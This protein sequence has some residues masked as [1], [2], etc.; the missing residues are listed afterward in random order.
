MTEIQK[1]LLGLLKEIDQICRENDITYYLIG[2]TALGAV[3]HR[4][5]IPW[6]DDADI[7]MTRENWLKFDALMK[8][9]LPEN[10]KYTTTFNTANNPA[11]FYRYAE[12]DSTLIVRSLS[13][14]DIVSGIIIDIFVLAPIPNGENERSKYHDWMRNYS[15]IL[16]PCFPVSFESNYYKYCFNRGLVRL[17]GRE[18]I[19]QHYFKKLNS[20]SEEDCTHYS[21]L[22][23]R[24]HIIYPKE[25]FGKPRYVP[26]ED[27]MLPIPTKAEDHFRILFGDDWNKLPDDR[28][29]HQNLIVNTEVPYTEYTKDYLSYTNKAQLY[30]QYLLRKRHMMRKLPH[31][32]RRKKHAANLYAMLTTQKLQ[33]HFEGMDN[34]IETLCEAKDYQGL[35]C[36][37]QPYYTAQM[38]RLLIENNLLLKV[39]PMVLQGAMIALCISGRYGK[40][41][42][43]IALVERCG[44]ELN[45]TMRSIKDLIEQKRKIIIALENQ[46]LDGA[47]TLLGQVDPCWEKDSDVLKLRLKLLN[48]EDRPDE[49]EHLIQT[50]MDIYPDDADFYKYKG[51]LALTRG[52]L[53]E[54]Q[55]CYQFA[56]KNSNDGMLHLEIQ[57]LMHCKPLDCAG[58]VQ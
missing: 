10:R 36:I 43:L 3:R 51:D 28:Q 20:F 8:E 58:G 39:S 26:F 30:N 23:A 46:D 11:V 22:Y 54:A 17:F 18:K 6:D 48:M 47:A 32:N 15:E 45:E 1:H 52:E 38:N 49:A 19:V 33:I 12:M 24:M 41:D 2:G 25:I 40:A 31:S 35:E 55:T 7:V 5:F 21:Y 16:C 9:H 56:L 4:G 13:Y 42:K 14:T 29:G 57:D 53:R 34:E 37:V 27:T 44:I 50:G